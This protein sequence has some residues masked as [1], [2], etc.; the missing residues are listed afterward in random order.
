M[1]SSRIART[2]LGRGIARPILQTRAR[3]FQSTRA[4]SS[5]QPGN[6]TIRYI[7]IAGA[8]I[9]PGLWWFVTNR[10]G[11]T[12]LEGP[13][14]G[15][16]AVEPGPSK[17]E[18]SHIISRDAYSL[19][20]KNVAGVS[21]YD[22]AQ[23]ASNS[24]CEDRF[25]H[26]KF[27]S[28]RDDGSQWMAWAV[29]DGHAGWQTADLLE[30][31][32]LPFVRHSLNQVKPAIKEESTAVEAV[33]GAI[34]R[35]FVS[36]DDSI[37][38]TASDT[39]QNGEPLQDKVK[40]LIPAY[41]G[42]CALLSVYD[43]ATS[44]L[45]VACTGDSR[46]V[47]GRKGSDGKWEAIPLSVDQTGNNE[48]E[49]A[50][51]EREHPGEENIVKDGRVLG[52][53]VSRA[54]GDGRW[55]WPLELQHDL[56]RRFYAPSPLTPRYDVRT[57]PY[58]TAEP[59]VTATKIDP[60]TSFLIMA[61]DG[62]WDTLSNRQA[63][64][65]VAKWLEPAAV[66]K[67]DNKP[68]SANAAFN[69]GQFRKGVDWRFVEGRTTVQDDNAAVHLMRN[70]LGGNHHEL[71]AGRL[72]FDSPFSRHLRDDITVQVVFFAGNGND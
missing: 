42:S 11:A 25:M 28:P 10:G 6:K 20:V 34:K 71:I 30:K 45:Y 15:H 50:R 1:L 32:L 40:K 9:A 61:T 26:G 63:V 35:A 51:L 72:A 67:V 18:V 38:N 46:A 17:D 4:S 43:P 56:R 24:P 48:E 8:A 55:K 53:M 37:I 44:I 27:P 33:E 68:E 2:R 41:A 31:Q 5:T 29:F 66:G 54:F 59:V 49:I 3:N 12:S 52:L 70:A 60:K 39:S 69:F 62:M 16:L 14:T 7:A 47:L 65:L 36:L 57:P 21:R 58:L 64:D 13:P 22:G 19:S 23:L